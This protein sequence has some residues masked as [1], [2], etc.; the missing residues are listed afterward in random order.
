MAKRELSTLK[1]F[2]KTVKDLLDSKFV[3][4]LSEHKKLTVK[5][6]FRKGGPLK[7]EESLPDQHAIKEFLLTL[8]LFI[9]KKE[10]ISIRKMAK[11]YSDLPISAQLKDKFSE[12]RGELNKYLDSDSPA[13]FKG[14]KLTRRQI[15]NVSLYGKYAHLDEK[16]IYDKWK[17]PPLFGLMLHFEFVS[18]LEILLRAIRYVTNLNDE[19]IQELTH[20][21]S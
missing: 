13:K 9:Q 21:S 14:K 5:I 18:I 20:S 2:N 6:S 8:R 11:L 17:K 19:A 3:Q 1:L 15:L 7:T 4:Y 16:E 12:L 10:E